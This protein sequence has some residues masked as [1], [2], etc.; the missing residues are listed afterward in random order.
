MTRRDE[1]LLAKQ[2]R[3]V[4]PPSSG[5]LVGIV[6]AVFVVGLL[7]GGMVFTPPVHHALKAPG[8]VVA[9]MALTNS[10]QPVLR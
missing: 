2:M 6:V 5:G 3:G 10:S 8:D 7:V 1:E 4:E 9:A